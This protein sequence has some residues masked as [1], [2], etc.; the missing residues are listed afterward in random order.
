MKIFKFGLSVLLSGVFF[1]AGCNQHP[2]PLPPAGPAISI[3]FIGNSYTFVNDLPKL[4]TELAKSGGHPVST[5]SIAP[6]GWTLAQHADSDKTIEKINE[7]KWDYIVLQEQ[8]VIPS[9]ESA[10]VNGMYPA[11]RS[12]ASKIQQVGAIPLLYMTWGRQKGLPEFGFNDYAGMQTQ[13]I[14][15]T[16]NIADELGLKVAPVGMAWK[17][18]L[19]RDPS[20]NFWQGDG[21]HP[22]LE[23]SYLGACVFYAVIYEKS[24]EGLDYPLEITKKRA[25][26][27][28]KIA[29][30][31]VLTDPTRWNIH[32]TPTAP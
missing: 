22:T 13:I 26:F 24:P 23:G 19:D 15:G 11:V 20:L 18:A 4:I 21:S 12:L 28:Q 10:R 30:E 27:L 3:L 1:T 8:S 16:M 17:N 25:G 32:V 29:A 6:G 14:L 31:T 5:S 9:V 7:R 2:A